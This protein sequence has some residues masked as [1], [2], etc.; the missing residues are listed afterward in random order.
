MHIDINVDLISYK[1]AYLFSSVSASTS[2]PVCDSVENGA[3]RR[4]SN[5]TGSHNR[6]RKST[7]A[8][9]TAAAEQAASRVAKEIREE[10]E[11]F[12]DQ[13]KK[14]QELLTILVSN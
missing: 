11:D 1:H 8:V 13:L 2:A 9:A 4:V 5:G 3:P 14:S 12:R 10:L 7:E 6:R